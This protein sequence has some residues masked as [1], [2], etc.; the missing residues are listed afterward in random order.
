[1]ENHQ[2][3]SLRAV[4]SHSENRSA[5]SAV[6]GMAGGSAVA[7]MADTGRPGGESGATTLRDRHYYLRDVRLEEGFE[8]DGET[9]IGT[10]TALY[11][12]EIKDGKIAALH[13]A[14]AGLADGLPRYGAHGQLLLP[15]MR[16][17]HIHLDK[18]FYGGPWQAPRPRQGKTIMDMIAR[19]QKLLPTLLPVAQQRAEGLIALLQSKGS[20]VARGHCNIDP[21]SGLKALEHVQRALENHQGD[22]SCEIVAFPQHGLLHS[23]VEGLLREAMTMGAAYVGGLDPT[24]VDG[25]MEKSLDA[26]FQIALDAGKGVDIHLHETSPAGVA[27]INYMVDTVEKNAALKGKVTISHAFA[28][29]TLSPQALSE[30]ATR[31]AAQGIAIASTVPIG[32][33]VM[34]LPQLSEKGVFVM[35]G[36]DSVIDHWSPFGSGDMLEKA[37]LYAQLYDGSD[38]FHL[39][40]ALS[41]ATGGVLPLDDSGK[42]AWPKAGDEAGFTLVPASCSAEAVARMPARTATFQQG[43]MVYGSVGQA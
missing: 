25:A 16:D 40:R 23:G 35:T 15:A 29:S 4:L 5:A 24:N 27:A 32:S 17:M 43:R 3:P 41:I 12:L 9:V 34:P 36:T 7:A 13:A 2:Q 8:Y 20:T 38:E 22:F 1:M 19:E 42:R 33:F 30:L 11:T 37:N 26:M 10:R 14:N 6:M 18:T 39:S 31:F 28:L 21:I